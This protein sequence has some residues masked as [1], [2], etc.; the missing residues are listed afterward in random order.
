MAEKKDQGAVR[1]SVMLVHLDG[2]ISM[3]GT[4]SEMVK[5]CST[6]RR[7]AAIAAPLPGSRG[8]RQT[9]PLEGLSSGMQTIHLWAQSALYTN[10]RLT[11]K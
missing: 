1:S 2:P 6:L 5:R 7:A 10:V 3:S 8:I 4:D 11:Y 9:E